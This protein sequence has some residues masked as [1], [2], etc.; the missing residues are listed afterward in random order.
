M[1]YFYIS[2]CH[3]QTFTPLVSG[4][5]RPCE[6]SLLASLHFFLVLCQLLSP[7]PLFFFSTISFSPSLWV[8]YVHDQGSF[9]LCFYLHS[10]DLLQIQYACAHSQVLVP[11]FYKNGIRCNVLHLYFLSWHCLFKVFPS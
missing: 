3:P 10:F 1:I 8:T 5:P 4:K 2:V 9:I 7:P 6:F 11:L